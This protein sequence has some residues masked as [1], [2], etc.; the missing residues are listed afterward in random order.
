MCVTQF[1]LLKYFPFICLGTSFDK[2]HPSVCFYIRRR[3]CV[4]LDIEEER[5]EKDAKCKWIQCTINLLSNTLKLDIVG[6]T[7]V[8]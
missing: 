3:V 8:L 7:C 6:A 2:H 4:R 1:L 5:E